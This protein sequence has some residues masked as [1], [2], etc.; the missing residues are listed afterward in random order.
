MGMQR[1]DRLSKSYWLV[2]TVKEIQIY[3]TIRPAENV[4]EAKVSLGHFATILLK[5]RQMKGNGPK[6]K[7][8][9]K[10]LLCMVTDGIYV[11]PPLHGIDP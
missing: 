5:V 4:H 1:E 10:V 11:F 8:V 7:K 2:Q 3:Y 9:K 6:T